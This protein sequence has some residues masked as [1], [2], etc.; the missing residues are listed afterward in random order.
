MIKGKDFIFRRQD[1]I[2]AAD[3]DDDGYLQECFVDTGDL[4]TILDCCNPKSIVVGR[5]GA[6]KTALLKIV[7][8]RTQRAI[9]IPPES[10]SLSYISNS[11]VLKFVER[12]GVNLDI[13]YRLLWR[14]V[15]TVELVKKHFQIYS[16][17]DKKT[18]WQKIR[19]TFT[20]QKNR[21]ALEYLE[22]W[23]KSFWEETEYRIQEVTQ[24][25]EKEIHGQIKTALPKGVLAGQLGG[26]CKVTDEQKGQIVERAQKVVNDVQI[27]QL[28]DIIS[29]LD[30]ILDDPQ[31]R[32]YIL[33]DRLDED[34]VESRLRYQLIRALVET[35]R[36]F[37]KIK[38][39]KIVVAIRQ[40]LLDRVFRIIRGAGFQEEKYDA[41]YVRIKW[42]DEQLREIMDKRLNHLLKNKYTK[43]PLKI[44][45]ILP[46]SID[47]QK[48]GEYIVSRTLKQPRDVIHLVN[49]CIEQV[50]DK[51]SITADAL[52]RAEG[53]Y[54]RDRLRYLADEWHSDIPNL[55]EFAKVLRKLSF[56]FPIQ[57]LDKPCEEFCLYFACEN[58]G[59]NDPKVNSYLS[60][61]AIQTAN[62]NSDLGLFRNSLVLAFYKIGILGVKLESYDSY[63]WSSGQRGSISTTEINDKTKLEVHPAFWRVFGIVN[64]EAYVNLRSTRETRQGHLSQTN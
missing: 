51:N 24:K 64:R 48:P 9:L 27:R 16:E 2:G 1:N 36:D 38:N 26:S 52:K 6:G 31:K 25:L 58:L 13:F 55:L 21:K 42:S 59:S 15:F 37:R 63:L 62:A 33:I 53:E 44:E 41:M 54:S 23:G 29:L 10:L 28:S 32:Y 17:D 46:R 30:E 3:A 18:F 40:D 5:T 61:L 8:N 47:G 22:N 34:W 11:T 19:L 20:D 12:L 45:D 56:R 14:H 57:S 4:E 49:K 7:E 35:I 60:Q 43:R 50:A 39:A